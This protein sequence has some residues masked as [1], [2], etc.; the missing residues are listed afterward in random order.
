MVFFDKNSNVNQLPVE[1]IN[2]IM[3]LNCAIAK[4]ITNQDILMQKI[5][6]VE[7]RQ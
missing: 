6:K 7:F 2:F 3:N 1:L 4:P 5:L